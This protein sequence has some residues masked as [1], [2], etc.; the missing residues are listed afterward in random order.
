MAD[1]PV[2][3]RRGS[4]DYVAPDMTDDE[5]ERLRKAVEHFQA[6]RGEAEA[7]DEPMTLF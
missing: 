7:D 3:A 2:F 1:Q 5:R 4:Y 6:K